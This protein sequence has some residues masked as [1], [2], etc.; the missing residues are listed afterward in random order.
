MHLAMFGYIDWKWGTY[1]IPGYGKTLPMQTLN[2]K[3]T[4]RYSSLILSSFFSLQAVD[5]I[6]KDLYIAARPTYYNILNLASQ[7]IV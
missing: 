6:Q 4:P 1:Q 2:F 5:V 3:K 7:L